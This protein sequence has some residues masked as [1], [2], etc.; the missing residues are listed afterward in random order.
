MHQHTEQREKTGGLSKIFTPEPHK[1]RIR[2]SFQADNRVLRASSI[3][4]LY[5]AC[6][7]KSQLLY[8]LQFSICDTL[9]AALPHSSKE[10]RAP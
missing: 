10:M 2:A 7:P 1:R 4:F 9:A 3:F 6:P 5:V 8:Q